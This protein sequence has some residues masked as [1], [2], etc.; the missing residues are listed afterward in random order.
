LEKKGNS[1]TAIAAS[2]TPGGGGW[3][4]ASVPGKGW[5]NS[6]DY[7]NGLGSPL[8]AY[9]DGVV[10]DSRAITQGGSPGNGKYAT[11]YRSFGETIAI[12][13]DDGNVVRYAHLS[14]G[15][16]YV[17][18]G[19]RVTGGTLI[20]LSGMTGNAS[21][22]HTHFEVNG[23]EVAKEWFQSHGI[24]LKTG[25]VTK[26]D[27]MAN[28]HK[29]EVVVD[30]MRTKDLF[31][32]LDDFSFVMG[33]LARLKDNQLSASNARMAKNFA[34][35]GNSE[36]NVEVNLYGTEISV[37]D[38]TK[39]VRKAIKKDDARKPGSRVG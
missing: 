22:P 19:Q 1:F 36:Y 11:P 6:H 14:P 3:R 16:R 21:G 4:K 17:R 5:V 25:G 39:A 35:E 29:Q 37:E 28:L 8:Y 34:N 24:G 26:S 2:T 9:N 7:R 13:G 33:G 30:P 20:G 15:K 27:G 12:R 32:S 10:V 23:Q 38:V 18:D 31:A